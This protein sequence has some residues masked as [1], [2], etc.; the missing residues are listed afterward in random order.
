MAAYFST[1]LSSV[2]TLSAA[3]AAKVP[4]TAQANRLM[5]KLFN[6]DQNA[7]IFYGGSTVSASNGIA[8]QP[9]AESDWIPCSGDIWC[10][11]TGGTTV[12]A[13]EGA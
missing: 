4:A 2:T 8:V 9:G 12:R 6:D 5:L 11:S 7:P 10:Y 3:T 13:L 1:P